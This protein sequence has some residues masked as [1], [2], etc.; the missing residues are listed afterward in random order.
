MAHHHQTVKGPSPIE[1]RPVTVKIGY[2]DVNLIIRPFRPADEPRLR[3]L[4]YATGFFGKPATLWIDTNMALFTDIWMAYYFQC[5]PDGIVVAEHEGQAIGYLLGC[6]DARHKQRFM[7]TR[8]PFY[9]LKRFITGKY[10]FG[11]KTMALLFRLLRDRFRYGFPRIPWR[12]YPANCHYNIAEEFRGAGLLFALLRPFAQRI[13]GLG[14][15]R[16]HGL[17]VLTKAEIKKRYFGIAEVIDYRRTTVFANAD[18]R[19]LFIMSAVA[20]IGRGD[21]SFWDMLLKDES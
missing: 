10:R 14:M 3:E 19:E 5:E 16:C 4:C 11:H 12:E 7:L 6:H 15:P 8:F 2:R 9:F 21:R 20:E 13:Y 17:L 1:P 18:T